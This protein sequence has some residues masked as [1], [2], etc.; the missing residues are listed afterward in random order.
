MNTDTHRLRVHYS[1]T[2]TEQAQLRDA[3]ATESTTSRTEL[4]F[5]LHDAEW[6]AETVLMHGTLYRRHTD[7]RFPFCPKDTEQV[8][9]LCQS[10]ERYE[11]QRKN[12][13]HARNA[14]ER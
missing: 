8:K 3:N 9:R 11:R 14:A 2:T 10:M 1:V 6:N 4:P 13:P 5:Y 7:Y 12:L